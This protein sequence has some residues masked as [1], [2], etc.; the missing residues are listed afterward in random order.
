MDAARRGRRSASAAG[1]R[2]ERDVMAITALE[3]FL[4]S[5]LD[6][7]G[8]L[9]PHPEVLELGES[10]WYGDVPVDKLIVDIRDS[11]LA[12]VDRQ[13]LLAG[14]DD[15]LSRDDEARLF[16]VAKIA[17]QRFTGYRSLTAIDLHGVT[18][19]RFDLNQPVPLD[20]QFDLT[21]DFGTGE[22]VFNVYQFFKTAHEMTRSGGTM[23]HGTPVTGWIDH[24]FYSFQPTLYWD[25]AS[26]NGYTVIGMAYGQLQPFKL[27]SMNRREDVLAMA[28]A[29]GFGDNGMVF[30]VL[31][32]AAEET[33][34][35]TPMQGFYDGSLPDRLVEAWRA[36][37]RYQ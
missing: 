31:R 16:A 33:P 36:E 7:A 19:Q 3:Y 30:A 35:R 10:N 6:A 37:L 20:R 26:T 24:G 22:H 21:L 11:R 23:I 34:F 29:G 15:A 12:M 27:K 4:L 2:Y 5:E 13:A 9:P 8:V 25:L 28:R 14:L 32:K 17:L 18:S 1:N